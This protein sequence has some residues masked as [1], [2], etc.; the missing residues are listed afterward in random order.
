MKIDNKTIGAL[1]FIITLAAVFSALL[2][3]WITI[4]LALIAFILWTIYDF[5][6]ET[7]KASV[8]KE[9]KKNKK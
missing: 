7:P 9:L 3:P 2:K 5:T 6:K 4:T 1:A 8:N